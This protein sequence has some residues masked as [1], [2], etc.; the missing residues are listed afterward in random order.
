MP[1]VQAV[2]IGARRVTTDDVIVV[3]SPY[4]GHEIG[5]V[6]A[7]GSAEVGQA[8]ASARAVLEGGRLAPWQRAAILDTAARLL[9]E[10]TEQFARIIAEE[11]AKPIK[12]ARIEAMRAVSTFTF[13]AVAARSLTGEMVPMDAADVGEGKLAFTL[14][15]PIGVVGAISP[16]NFP[17]NLVAHKVAPAIAAGCPVV[18]KPAS[19]TP[20]SALALADLLLDECGLPPGH[21]NV[22]TGGGGT[23]GNALVDSPDV[24]MITF[25]GSPDVGWGIKARAPRKK[26]GL[27]LGNNA[28]VIAEPDA[29]LAT[30]ARKV[31]VAGFSHAGQSCISTQRIYVHQ[32]VGEKFLGELVPLVEALVVGDPLDEATD[33]S[34]LI[35]A[36]ERDRVKSWI[37]EAVDGGAHVRAGGV[38]RDDGMLAPTVLTNVTPEMKVCSQEVFGPVVAVQTYQELDDALRLANDT[39]YGLQAAIFTQDLSV[40]LRAARSLD[41]GGVLI[42]EVPTWRADQMPY[43]GVRDSGNTREGPRYA[44]EE[45]TEPRL[46][47]VQA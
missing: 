29:D 42:N 46:V 12:T 17:L 1:E 40:A 21:L 36:G 22:V 3:R 4:D 30:L 14:R 25:T 31:S 10:R 5:R 19:Q 38:V 9:S 24:A 37:D 23:V 45:M 15:V 2:P 13:A 41:F 26:V 11:A 7:C 18:L 27:E 6:P 39:R 44:V 34:A 35:T 16:F 28:P 47:I 43:G 8:V 32:D 20:R 33:V